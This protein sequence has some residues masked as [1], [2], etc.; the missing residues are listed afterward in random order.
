MISSKKEMINTS[1][2][3]RGRG[4]KKNNRNR[5]DRQ[6]TRL[7]YQVVGLGSGRPNQEYP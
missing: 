4:K 6:P 5:E 1:R 2:N 7:I 3:I